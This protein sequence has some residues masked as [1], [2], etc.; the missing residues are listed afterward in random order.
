MS[1]FLSSN[2][3]GGER[4][5]EIALIFFVGLAVIVFGFFVAGF[6]LLYLLPPLILVWPLVK[7]KP[8]VGSCLL[9]V[10]ILLVIPGLV[11]LPGIF[12]LHQH[13]VADI[14]GWWRIFSTLTP[15]LTHKTF[16]K[17]A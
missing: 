7:K 2:A 16:L 5:T 10:L 9:D 14:S 11:A 8:D 4:L 15:K 3:S 17:R 6:L 13:L 12:V 1:M